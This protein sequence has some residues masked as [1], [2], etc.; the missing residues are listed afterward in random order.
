VLELQQKDDLKLSSDFK[1]LLVKYLFEISPLKFATASGKT[2]NEEDNYVTT[3]LNMGKPL[4]FPYF[5]IESLS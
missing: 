4:E 1:R 2:R 5:P 3:I